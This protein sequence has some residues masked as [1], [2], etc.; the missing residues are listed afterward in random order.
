[1]VMPRCCMRVSSRPWGSAK[2]GW[3]LTALAREPF[4]PLVHLEIA[5]SYYSQRR[6]DDAVDWADRTLLLDETHALARELVTA[7]SVA[8]GDRRLE[9]S[10][11]FQPRSG[12]LGRAEHY[13]DGVFDYALRRTPS[14]RLA[15]LHSAVLCSAAGETERAF[16]HLESA[17][18]PRDSGLLRLAIAP[19]W[20]NLR[21]DPRFDR[22]LARMGLAAAI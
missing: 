9:R 12:L 22:C 14:R 19:Q 11:V 8:R 13:R 4:L 5:M 21:S 17:I 10:E 3:K 16:Q 2:K 6:Y 15:D 18:D 1:M 20:D 7:A